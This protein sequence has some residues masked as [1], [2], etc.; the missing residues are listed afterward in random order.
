MN[1]LGYVCMAKAC[2]HMRSLR[3]SIIGDRSR[4]GHHDARG[5]RMASRTRQVY[6]SRL[7]THLIIFLYT[8]LG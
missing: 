2:V 7:G 4:L 6:A 5:G 8:P 3:L 1:Q